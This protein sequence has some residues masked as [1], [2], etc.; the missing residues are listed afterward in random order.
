MPPPHRRNVLLLSNVELAPS[1]HVLKFAWPAGDPVVF[2]PGQYAT[3]YLPRQGKSTPRSYSFF[4]SADHHDRFALLIKRVP[5]GF[6]STYLCNLSPLERPPLSVLAPLGRFVLADPDDRTVVLVATGTGLAPFVPM[7][8]RLGKEHPGNPTW[9]F[10]GSRHV[11]ELVDREELQR[12]QRT[13]PNF[14]FVPVVSRP[15]I[16]GS[17]TGDRGHVQEAVQARFP[18]LSHADVYLCGVNEMVNEMQKIAL[19][20]GCPKERIFVERYGEDAETEAR[21]AGVLTP[22]A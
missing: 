16:D 20:L 15:P 17:W 21:T 19:R 13:W 14:H 9:L 4:S 5:D 3:F 22:P 6:G 11:E 18:D 2:D 12:R 1:L 10:F 7:L 8:E